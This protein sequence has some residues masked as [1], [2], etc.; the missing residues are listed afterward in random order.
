MRVDYFIGD[1]LGRYEPLY[2]K[3]TTLKIFE[4]KNIILLISFCE[5]ILF[6]R[7]AR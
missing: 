6:H 5:N 2:V 3:K 4:D 7:L 1:N